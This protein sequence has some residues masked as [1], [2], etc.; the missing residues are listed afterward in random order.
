MFGLK[1]AQTL[2]KAKWKEEDLPQYLPWLYFAP[3]SS[4]IVTKDSLLLAFFEMSFSGDYYSGNADVDAVNVVNRLLMT[5]PPHTTIW[6]EWHKERP[7][8]KGYADQSSSF[9]DTFKTS[10]DLESFRTLDF[11]E[12][13]DIFEAKRYLTVSFTPSIGKSG[14]QEDSFS[15][16]NKIIIDMKARL[17]SAD[18]KARE[19]TREEVCTYL[20]SCISDRREEIKVPSA[21]NHAISDALWDTDMDTQMMPMKLGDKFVTVLSVNDFP[22]FEDSTPEMLNTLTFVNGDIR[23]VTRFT[24]LSVEEA[25]K[26]IDDKRRT[27]ASKRFSGKDIL[28]STVFKE[29]DMMEDTS[30]L[31]LSEQCDAAM[32]E[33]GDKYNFGFYTLDLVI[34]SESEKELKKTAEN[35]G[36]RLSKLGFVWKEETLNLFP[37]WLSSLPGNTESNPRRFFISTGNVACLLSLTSLYKGS[38]Q[39]TFLQSVSGRDLPNA[40]ALLASGDFY[41]LNL[42]GSGDVG[43]TFVV[44]PTG[45]GKSILLSFLAA[46]WGKYPNARVI[47][48]DKGLSSKKVVEGNGGRVYHPGIDDTCFQPLRN[49]SERLEECWNFLS[50]IAG[51]QNVSLRPTDK[52]TML[53][54]LNLLVPGHESLS[55]YRDLLMGRDH[56]SDFVAAMA[57][58]T[59]G[60]AWG[61]LFDASSDTLDDASW[62]SYLTIEMGELMEMGDEAIIPALTYITGRLDHV[63]QDKRPTLLILDEAW[64]YMRHPVF[65]HF[66]ATWLKTLRKNN[67]FVI[68]AT[69]EVS[70]Y[71]S[72]MENILTNCHTRIILPAK[73]AKSGPLSDLFK[74]IGLSETDLEVIS[75]PALMMPK[76]DY[77]V[78]QPEGR[79]IVNLAL[80]DRQLDL[81]R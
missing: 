53:E 46:E 3:S 55:L 59:E 52:E 66:I 48:L 5:L 50:S 20:H 68:L 43:H 69:Q 14:I 80:T 27:F 29:T 79:A 40:T 24:T 62:P 45:A 6:Y 51:V 64:V 65:R 19:L 11:E 63:F 78:M 56:E 33:N 15:S 16:F 57:N 1:K 12:N 75:S 60:G 26:F 76:R 71:D 74:K 21:A 67:V 39:N 8:D 70:D 18:I 73:D 54:T 77:Y 22:W 4:R 49:A 34:Q 13:K 72:V 81:L 10:R 61:S 25:K 32:E 35:I 42:N 30:V 37:S 47:F 9:P 17:S 44:G 41:H 28:A 38:V 2:K 58:Y 7:E 23:W 31:S 36:Q